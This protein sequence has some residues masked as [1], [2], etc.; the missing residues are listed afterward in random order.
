MT[1][2]SLN[3]RTLSLGL[4]SHCTINQSNYKH[5]RINNTLFRAWTDTRDLFQFMDARQAIA[6]CVTAVIQAILKSHS[7]VELNF[8]SYEKFINHHLH[9]IIQD[10]PVKDWHHGNTRHVIHLGN[11]HF[12]RPCHKETDGSTVPLYASEARLRGLSYVMSVSLDMF[13][14]RYDRADDNSEWKLIYQESSPVELDEVIVMVGSSACRSRSSGML[15]HENPLNTGGYFIYDGR[16]KYLE[17]NLKLRDNYPRAYFAPGSAK[18]LVECEYRC[19][20]EYMAK[21]GC[22]CHMYMSVPDK[23]RF[24]MAKSS[25]TSPLQ[26]GHVDILG[27]TPSNDVLFDLNAKNDM[28]SVN[29]TFDLRHLSDTLASL[30][31]LPSLNTCENITV[32]LPNITTFNVNLNAMLMMLGCTSIDAMLETILP[33]MRGLS[34]VDEAS[35]M[36][37]IHKQDVN[38][39]TMYALC[40][41]ILAHNSFGRNLLTLEEIR[42]HPDIEAIMKHIEL[43]MP[44]LVSP[45]DHC[46]DDATSV[47]RIHGTSYKELIA[48]F[49]IMLIPRV[50]APAYDQPKPLPM[51]RYAFERM[52]KSL[53]E[54]L[55]PNAGMIHCWQSTFAK[56]SIVGMCA[57]KTIQVALGFVE[58]DDL[59]HLNLKRLLMVGNVLTKIYKQGFQTGY[60]KLRDMIQLRTVDMFKEV[61][62]GK[63][64]HHTTPFSLN[65]LAVKH[66]C[67]GQPNS[68]LHSIIASGKYINPLRGHVEFKGM[69]HE[70]GHTSPLIRIEEMRKIR[71]PL[72]DRSN[73]PEAHQFHPSRVDMVCPAHTP[74]KDTGLHTYLAKGTHVR[75]GYELAELMP[76]VLQPESH[77][78]YSAFDLEIVRLSSP[79]TF[80]QLGIMVP[81]HVNGNPIG[82]TRYPMETMAALKAS[83]MSGWIPYDVGITWVG[84]PLYEGGPLLHPYSNYI[85]VLGDCGAC[86]TPFFDLHHLWKVPRLV[87]KHFV[88]LKREGGYKAL[89]DDLKD[90][91]CIAYLDC[92]EI[93]HSRI[94]SSMDEM[95]ANDDRYGAFFSRQKSGRRSPID[96]MFGELSRF[97]RIGKDYCHAE[98]VR[99]STTL[100]PA[101]SRHAI[102]SVTIAPFTH[103][104]ISGEFLFGYCASSLVYPSNTNGARNLFATSMKSQIAEHVALNESYLAK[105]TSLVLM[106]PKRMLTESIVDRVVG[107]GD[108]AHFGGQEEKLTATMCH[109]K[110][111]EDSTCQV[112]SDYRQGVMISSKTFKATVRVTGDASKDVAQF[113]KPTSDCVGLKSSN[114]DALND[115]GMPKIGSLI[116][117]GDAIIGVTFR[118]KKSYTKMGAT[119]Y[120]RDQSVINTTKTPQ[121]VSRI[122]RTT[123]SR[124]YAVV[125]VICHIV[126]VPELGNK[127]TSDGQKGLFGAVIPHHEMPYFLNATSNIALTIQN[128]RGPASMPSRTTMGEQRHALMCEWI[129]KCSGARELVDDWDG[130]KIN[131]LSE[132]IT[133]GGHDY[134][135]KRPVFQ[136]VMH[137][138]RTKKSI[139]VGMFNFSYLEHLVID[140]YKCRTTGQ[141]DLKTRQSCAGGGKGGGNKNGEM[142]VSNIL[143]QGAVNLLRQLLHSGSDAC[144]VTLCTLCGLFMHMDSNKHAYCHR[145]KTSRYI[146]EVRMPFAMVMLMHECYASGVAHRLHATSPSAERWIADRLRAWS[147]IIDE[148]ANVTSDE[149]D[150]STSPYP[151]S[152]A[153]SPTSPAYSPT[154]PAYNPTCPAEYSP[155]SPA[156]SPTSPAYIPASP[157]YCPTSPVPGVNS[158]Y[159]PTSPAYEWKNDNDASDLQRTTEEHRR[160]MLLHG[161]TPE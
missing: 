160:V 111:A 128:I 92:E 71:T 86:T 2:F 63:R 80:N 66:K 56:R 55:L 21:V 26:E 62:T 155:S 18:H 70:L 140:Y 14:K 142:E 98:H 39:H 85:S 78:I 130:K 82:F 125:S 30:H 117:Q 72:P 60:K 156:Y 11:L 144:L 49:V 48:N 109:P 133:S 12:S 53:V 46:N 81:V 158:T 76:L 157:I 4:C 149:H 35:R 161:L 52:R 73:C 68:C 6:S 101:F 44:L 8:A 131:Q 159:S 127:G 69:A 40:H 41:R 28:M 90:N 25:S 122:V 37:M 141:V 100:V 17:T 67:F 20:I 50:H 94:A 59:D 47:H 31:G 5:C 145:C 42:S 51:W 22:S 3:A 105:G 137:G 132:L 27:V 34:T 126:V 136:P 91:G 119:Y 107:F 84:G 87:A 89:Y 33:W 148:H 36:E 83:R 153:Y 97:C 134:R 61:E 123:N 108:G 120:K 13:Y 110:N 102:R 29:S 116:R 7:P 112:R 9:R 88:T 121:V 58:E 32:M 93:A 65:K 118:L 138:R 95:M 24:N 146:S 143:G 152:P 75:Q 43:Q 106:N 99:L 150:V 16:E 54:E 1:F 135:L 115:D 114:Y 57:L 154:S 79:S 10:H 45:F 113:E 96:D 124:G 19:D 151:T 147:A 15:V 23:K 64:Q 77:C 104:A 129:V 74:S 139:F 103:L 38:Q